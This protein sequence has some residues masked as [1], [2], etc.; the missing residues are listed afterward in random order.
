MLHIKDL[1]IFVFFIVWCTLILCENIA[2]SQN[3]VGIGTNNPN[4]NAVLDLNATDNNQ[5]FLAPRLTTSQRNNPGFITSLQN[6]DNG[7]LIF[8]SDIGSFFYWFNNQWIEGFSSDVNVILWRSG[9]NAPNNNSGKEGDFYLDEKTGN[10]YKRG[11]AS[12][13][14]ISAKP[15]PQ[16]LSSTKNGNL[17][18]VKITEGLGISL[19]ID[20]ADADP[21]NELISKISIEDKILLITEGNKNHTVDLTNI[22]SDNQQLKS[23]KA[24]NIIS[25]ELER[26]NN[27]NLNI[28]DSDSDPENEIQDLSLL[29]NILKITKNPLASEID[30]NSINTDNQA[31][32]YNAA[33]QILSLTDGGTVDL[34]GLVGTDDQVISYNANTKIITLERGGT[35]DLND[36]VN[37]DNQT[38]SK[39]GNSITISNGNS[40]TL[41]NNTPTEDQVLLWKSGSWTAASVNGIVSQTKYYSVDPTAFV[42]IGKDGYKIYYHEDTGNEGSFV[43][44]DENGGIGAP[45]NLP[46]GAT[47]SRITFYYYDDED[48]GADRDM[49]FQLVRKDRQNGNFVNIVSGSSSL[50]PTFA[51]LSLP[52]TLNNV[53]D[54]SL[55]SYRIKV[56][57]KKFGHITN[58]SGIRHRLYSV[59]IEYLE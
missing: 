57:M 8:D 16:N 28:A 24:G 55:Y 31:L 10:I 36:L 35:I 4:R 13:A 39:T 25:L 18:D 15:A 38:L 9:I 44:I 41:A 56:D 58:L 50:R 6:T 51:S 45:V 19:N 48:G 5:G 14:L 42:G 22:N 11:A 32:S 17:I 2:Y 34:S 47:I 37:T 12:Y 53:V 1:H 30:L 52:T 3:S 43:A 59:V 27:V 49:G 21:T 23:T 29:N 26:G 46:H 54:N 40:I 20:D 7:M 33:T